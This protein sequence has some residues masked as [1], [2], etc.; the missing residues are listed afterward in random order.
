MLQQPSADDYVVA[1]GESHSVREFL[2]VAAAQC[3]LDWSKHVE[4]DPRY[5]RPTEVDFLWGDPSKAR[6]KLGWAPRVT[7][8]ELVR[9]MI[10]CDPGSGAPGA[11]AD[12]GRTQG[13]PT[14]GITH[15]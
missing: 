12:G 6:A 13:G 10:E 15:Q 4:T 5:F 1:T 14:L 9:M 2:D 11:D 3:G 8:E 7:F